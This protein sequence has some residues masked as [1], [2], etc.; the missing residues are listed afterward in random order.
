MPCRTKTDLKLELRA[1]LR[2]VGM[3]GSEESPTVGHINHSG[4]PMTE[5]GADEMMA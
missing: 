3:T 5:T 4:E 1:Q 2:V